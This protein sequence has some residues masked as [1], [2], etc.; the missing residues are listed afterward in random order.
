M[1]EPFALSSLPCNSKFWKHSCF[2]FRIELENNSICPDN[3]MTQFKQLPRPSTSFPSKDKILVLALLLMYLFLLTHKV[4]S[5]GHTERVLRCVSR[6]RN[7]LVCLG[8]LLWYNFLEPSLDSLWRCPEHRVFL[9]FSTA[10]V[11]GLSPR[12]P[13]QKDFPSQIRSRAGRP[14]GSPPSSRLQIC[15]KH[16]FSPFPSSRD[17]TYLLSTLTS[18]CV[19]NCVKR[20]L[21][22]SQQPPWFLTNECEQGLVFT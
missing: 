16:L 20:I 14:V 15:P 6:C 1:P 21:E 22:N 12:I 3:P 4:F 17:Q 11:K 7:P 5:P 9:C 18:T 2:S 13:S 8:P 10:G 19:Q